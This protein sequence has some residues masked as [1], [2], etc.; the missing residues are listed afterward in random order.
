MCFEW[1]WVSEKKKGVL[2]K[3]FGKSVQSWRTAGTGGMGMALAFYSSLF[4]STKEVDL[5]VG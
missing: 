2:R 1:T 4:C 3:R 5:V